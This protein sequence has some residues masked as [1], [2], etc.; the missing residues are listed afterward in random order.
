MGLSPQPR[1][2]SPEENARELHDA[3]LESL[4]IHGQRKIRRNI[5]LRQFGAIV[6]HVFDQ[7]G[8]ESVRPIA[9]RLA[10]GQ[11]LKNPPIRTRFESIPPEQ[12]TNALLGKVI[13]R[14]HEI[15]KA[16]GF[17]LEANESQSGQGEL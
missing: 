8:N 12:R 6:L 5:A 17:Q 10:A 1:A 3:I 14:I 9:A 2:G 13:E 16:D 7:E 4:M 15:Y 11:V